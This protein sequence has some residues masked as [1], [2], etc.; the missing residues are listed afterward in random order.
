MKKFWKNLIGWVLY[1]GFLVGLIYGTPRGLSYALKTN[2]PMASIT[3][4]SMWPALKRGDLI[5]I[6]GIESGEEIKVGDIIVFQNPKGLT[7]HRVKEIREDTLV[8]RGDANNVDDAPIQYE[9]IVGKA[10]TI[11]NKPLRIP[12]VGLVSVF[13]NQ[14]NL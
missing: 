10:L 1:I 13:I 5:L 7:I 14:N 3:S 8:T 2:T 4:G 6:Q 11:N 12:L 9:E